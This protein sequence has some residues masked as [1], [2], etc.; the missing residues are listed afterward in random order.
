MSRAQSPTR[1][2][3]P[4]STTEEML[5]RLM[6][7]MES[8]AISF[9][10]LKKENDNRIEEISKLAIKIGCSG[11]V[12]TDKETRQPEITNDSSSE[13]EAEDQRIQENRS[14]RLSARFPAPTAPLTTEQATI[15][16]K[17]AVE[18]IRGINGQDGIG[19]EDFIRTLKRV[20]NPI[21][22]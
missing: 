15:N 19:V 5:G 13:N 16:A 3:F 10:V 21:F 9:N 8:L 6:T 1:A 18:T 14:A 17:I 22:C 12:E 20:R 7:Q 11:E 2:Q 4:S